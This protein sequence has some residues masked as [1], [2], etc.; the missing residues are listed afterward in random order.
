MGRIGF[1]S[2][3]YMAL[4]I[5]LL[6]CQYYEH[7]NQNK[8]ATLYN[9]NQFSSPPQI[10]VMM[11]KYS[12]T[13]LPGVAIGVW[14]C[15]RKTFYSWMRFCGQSSSC[16]P[17]GLVVWLKQR[18]MK[19]QQSDAEASW[20]QSSKISPNLSANEERNS[21]IT[22]HCSSETSSRDDSLTHTDPSATYDSKF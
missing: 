2:L 15:S 6:V 1:F 17:S 20:R 18:R 7:L 19:C 11:I 9:C 14:I 10:K 4:T 8:W 12:V 13:M 21:L 5:T 3:I 22:S 16:A